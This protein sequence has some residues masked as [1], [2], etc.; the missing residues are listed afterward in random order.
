MPSPSYSNIHDFFRTRVSSIKKSI[1]L[2]NAFG[3]LQNMKVEL[4]DVE[5]EC[6]SN[7][8]IQVDLKFDYQKYAVSI[9][10]K[11]KIS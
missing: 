1:A 5:F 4:R 11:N 6:I 2:V 9:Q 3:I 7:K 8:T 10:N